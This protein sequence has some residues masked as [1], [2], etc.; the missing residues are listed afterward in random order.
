MNLPAFLL[1]DIGGASFTS[2]EASKIDHDKEQP[3]AQ[4]APV[5]ATEKAAVRFKPSL[6]VVKGCHP[7]SAVNAAGET[8]AGLKGTDKPDGKCKG[9]ILGSQ[10]YGRAGRG[11]EAVTGTR[12]RVA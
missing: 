10:V 5:T 12:C 2:I 4:L 6:E 8:S 1:A 9:S 7:Y 11:S 3:F